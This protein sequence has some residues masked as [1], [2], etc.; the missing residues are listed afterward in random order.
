MSNPGVR[1][2]VGDCPLYAGTVEENVAG[3]DAR[4]EP[5]RV[6][7]ALDEVRLGDRVR[8]SELGLAGLAGEGDLFTT[9]SDA[10]GLELATALVDP[11]TV[12]VACGALGKVPVA[13]ANQVLARLAEAGTAVLVLECD[14]PLP[15]GAR[16]IP[17]QT[18]GSERTE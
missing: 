2:L 14:S 15:A 7:R 17:L 11:P 9:T 12:A 1:L 6:W 3:F 5:E 13:V 10:A 18:A 4:V 16:R 8:A